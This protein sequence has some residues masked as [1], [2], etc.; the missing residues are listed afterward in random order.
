[1]FTHSSYS[2]ARILVTN[3]EKTRETKTVLVTDFKCVLFLLWTWTWLHTGDFSSTLT[4]VRFLTCCCLHLSGNLEMDFISSLF[5]NKQ[6]W[7][8]VKLVCVFNQVEE[9]H[10]AYSKLN[11]VFLAKVSS[12]DIRFVSGLW[13]VNDSAVTGLCL[14]FGSA[15]KTW[16]RGKTLRRCVKLLVQWA[17]NPRR[18]TSEP[19]VPHRKHIT[20]CCIMQIN[21]KQYSV[22]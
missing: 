7:K 14:Y 3:R 2:Q 6:R 19:P 11:Y 15:S 4:L 22:T 5:F 17:L 10:P 1:M 18:Y 16:A 9:L 13:N 21:L 20:A 12:G 8:F